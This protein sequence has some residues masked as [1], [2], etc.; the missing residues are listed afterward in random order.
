ME[1][2]K[3][4]DIKDSLLILKTAFHYQYSIND[5][6]SL[7]FLMLLLKDKFEVMFCVRTRQDY[8]T[9]GQH[10]FNF[11]F[12]KK[13]IYHIKYMKLSLNV[14]VEGLTVFPLAISGICILW[15]V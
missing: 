4:E 8:Y 15:N 3:F 12:R 10:I 5:V 14:S 9:E 2:E 11:W 1:S 6:C 7:G 13:Y